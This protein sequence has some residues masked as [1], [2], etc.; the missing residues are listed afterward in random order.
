MCVPIEESAAERI[1]PPKKA[2]P[3]KLWPNEGQ[4]SL[5]HLRNLKCFTILYNL[6]TQEFAKTRE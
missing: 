4:D 6:N 1:S 5:F 2:K 3:D